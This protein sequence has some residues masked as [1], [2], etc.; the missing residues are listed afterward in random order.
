MNQKFKGLIKPVQDVPQHSRRCGVLA[1]KVGSSFLWDKW[2]TYHN[3]T[4][5]QLD[6]CQVVQ[7][8]TA[9]KDGVSSI[10]VGCGQKN[11]KRLKKPEIGHFVKA[12]VPPKVKLFEFPVTPENMLPVGYMFSVRHFTP[13]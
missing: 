2:G 3:L 5:M 8:K 13:G 6:R 1:T 10:Q 12:D 7:T 11:L 9:E 4:V